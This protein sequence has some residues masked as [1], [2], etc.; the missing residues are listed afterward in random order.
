[1]LF[2]TESYTL[3]HSAVFY[4]IYQDLGG[5]WPLTDWTTSG[6]WSPKGLT[7]EAPVFSKLPRLPT[8]LGQFVHTAPLHWSLPLQ[9]RQYLYDERVVW[10]LCS[11]WRLLYLVT[12]HIWHIVY[13]NMHA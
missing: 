2:S 13:C 7:T 8:L 6:F 1:M 4:A 12:H 3:P 9:V 11:R 5:S 10:L